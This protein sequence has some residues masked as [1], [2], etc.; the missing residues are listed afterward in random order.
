MNY[1][2]IYQAAKTASIKKG[3]VMRML[4]IIFMLTLSWSAFSS[5]GSKSQRFIASGV[6]PITAENYEIEAKVDMWR[7]AY[8]V[9]KDS[10]PQ[11]TSEILI[12]DVGTFFAARAYFYCDDN[13]TK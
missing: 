4:I 8:R 11:K 5:V 1:S 3:G 7:H 6:S 9:C 2:S 10:E 13:L 12:F